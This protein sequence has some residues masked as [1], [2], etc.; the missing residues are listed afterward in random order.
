MVSSRE[1]STRRQSVQS[2]AAIEPHPASTAWLT[3]GALTLLSEAGGERR[4][5]H[6]L[7]VHRDRNRGLGL[8]NS[9]SAREDQHTGADNSP[10]RRKSSRR[11]IPASMTLKQR[12]RTARDQRSER[13][14]GR[15]RGRGLQQEREVARVRRQQRRRHRAA[16]QAKRKRSQR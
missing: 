15:Y 3:T 4:A 6:G 16:Q 10:P 13:A 5:E 2:H 8:H 7:A 11:S 1:A 9:D 12:K 14:G